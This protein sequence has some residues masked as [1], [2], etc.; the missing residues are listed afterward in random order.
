[1]CAKAWKCSR[2]P[3]FLGSQD[4]LLNTACC[5]PVQGMVACIY[6]PCSQKAEA[7]GLSKFE[8]YMGLDYL[9]DPILKKQEKGII[10]VHIENPKLIHWLSLPSLKFNFS[11]LKLKYDE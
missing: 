9:Q 2:S 3:A 5:F 8:V 6:S 1:M 11:K 10:M 7:G 4:R